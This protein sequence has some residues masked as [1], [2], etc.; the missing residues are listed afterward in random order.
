L[1]QLILITALKIHTN[2]WVKASMFVYN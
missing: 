2:Y 1:F